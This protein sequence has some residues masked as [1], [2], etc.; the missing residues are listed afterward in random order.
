MPTV[1][2]SVADQKGRAPIGHL[3]GGQLDS[4][5]G[6]SAKLRLPLID[7]LSNRLTDITPATF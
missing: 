1:Q 7:Y 4:A 5:L 3:A 6:T 2:L